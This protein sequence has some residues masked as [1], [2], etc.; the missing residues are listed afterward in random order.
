[1]LYVSLMLSSCV[2]GQVSILTGP[3]RPVL[4][5][6]DSY[7]RAGGMV[8]ILTGPL[9]PVLLSVPPGWVVMIQGFNPHRPVKAGAFTTNAGFEKALTSFQ[10]SPAR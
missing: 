1:M 9:R 7:R 5:V 6:G 3:L 10:S 2:G 4:Y 8:S